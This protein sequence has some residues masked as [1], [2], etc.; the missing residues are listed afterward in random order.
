MSSEY[1]MDF[2]L[3]ALC[4]PVF[5]AACELRSGSSDQNVAESADTI[6]RAVNQAES[7][8]RLDP[9]LMRKFQALRHD[10]YFFIDHIM[11]QCFSRWKSLAAEKLRIVAGDEMFCRD[12]E[13]MLD[14]P[15]EHMDELQVF[16]TCIGLGFDGSSV[17]GE[18]HWPR[19]VNN[20]MRVTPFSTPGIA[21]PPP[22]IKRQGPIRRTHWPIFLFALLSLALLGIIG[23]QI[24]QAPVK[25]RQRL[26][27]LQAV[28]SRVESDNQR[29][30]AP[31][32]DE[33]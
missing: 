3:S 31:R 21:A 24:W 26:A 28:A 19:L 27:R 4:E 9:E 2:P 8:A 12:L 6:T 10:L 33:K 13:E 11:A 18:K 17:I 7:N 5:A 23:W 22:P 1:A 30:M 32:R 16:R 15:E 14:D 20:L 25:Y 29:S